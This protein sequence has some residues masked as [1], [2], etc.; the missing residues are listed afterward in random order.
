MIGKRNQPEI[1]NN[2]KNWTDSLERI[3]KWTKSLKRL[4]NGTN[5]TAKILLETEFK[6]QKN[7][8]DS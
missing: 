4:K 8:T 6:N 2:V 5:W 7:G 3:K 1:K